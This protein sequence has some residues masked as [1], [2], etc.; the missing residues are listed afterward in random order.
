MELKKIRP[1]TPSLRHL[2]Y[3]K[4]SSLWFKKYIKGSVTSYKR[5]NGRNNSGTITVYNKSRGHKK[6]YR[7]IDLKR[8]NAQGIVVGIEYDPF[9]TAYIARVY[10][11]LEKKNFYILSPKN[12]V[13]GSVV[14][15]GSNAKARLGNALSLKDIPVGSLIHNLT[16]TSKGYGQIARSAG[17]FAQLL[18]KTSKYARVRIKSGEV[19]LVP[20]N[21]SATIGSVSNEKFFLNVIAKAGRSRWLG[22]RP[23]VR[24]VAMNPI[25]HPHGGGEG[26][27]SGGRPSVTPWGKPTKAK[28]LKT[29]RSRN[30]LILVNR[31][32]NKEKDK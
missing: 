14:R 28:G 5:K 17:N 19:R 6:L 9:R 24:G 32:F 23:K 31:C 21:F 29:S 16:L 20:V 1:L 18:Q 11:F 12:L 30:K 15:S 25:D 10:N 4:L 22:K 8:S 27:T 13:V 3:Y 2:K 26:R 7:F